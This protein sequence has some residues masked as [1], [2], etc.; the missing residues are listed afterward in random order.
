MGWPKSSFGFFHTI[1]WEI[2]NEIFGQPSTYPDSFLST[3]PYQ[4]S[5]ESQNK[6]KVIPF[7]FSLKKDESLERLINNITNGDPMLSSTDV[8]DST[9]S[10]IDAALFPL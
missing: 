8:E 6:T 7:V 5:L 2:L 3:S 1:L 10:D 4:C 9:P